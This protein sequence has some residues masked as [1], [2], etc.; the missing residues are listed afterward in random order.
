MMKRSEIRDRFGIEGSDFGDCCV[1]Y[2][3]T[4]CGLIQQDK[5]VIART[6][7]A[8]GTVVQPY[9]APK[10]GMVM[11]QPQTQHQQGIQPAPT[12]QSLPT[13]TKSPEPAQL[14]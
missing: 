14:A 3:C 4:C 11:P 9:Q 12:A 5:E 1:A 8:Q 6:A 2:W 10:E 13:E 7:G